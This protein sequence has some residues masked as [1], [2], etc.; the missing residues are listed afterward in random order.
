M[1]MYT[2]HVLVQSLV[3]EPKKMHHG[4]F[5]LTQLINLGLDKVAEC[6]AHTLYAHFSMHV[7]LISQLW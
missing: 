7:I 2:T 1:I 4:A 6:C 5:H 3:T